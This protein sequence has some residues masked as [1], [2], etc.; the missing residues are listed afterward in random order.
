[1]TSSSARRSM[2]CWPLPMNDRIGGLTIRLHAVRALRVVA[3]HL[4][5]RSR[6]VRY[7]WRRW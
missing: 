5:L 7:T 6:A 2:Y 4:H 1:M 3:P